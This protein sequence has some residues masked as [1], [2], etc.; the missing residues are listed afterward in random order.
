VTDTDIQ[1]FQE[2]FNNTIYPSPATRPRQPSTAVRCAHWLTGGLLTLLTLLIARRQQD[3]PAA[4]ITF[5]ALT[6][7]MLLL[8]PVC[9]LH[10]F[11]LSLPLAMGSL[12]AVWEGKQGL[13][14]RVATPSVLVIHGVAH[15]LPHFP[16]LQLLRDCGLA[17]Y[18]TLLLWLFGMVILLKRGRSQ[19][20]LPLERSEVSGAA[21]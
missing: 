5:G 1:S 20:A 8:S 11:C 10:Y 19:R 14:G 21:A 7:I 3:G 2:V 9:H 6:V 16:A 4:V 12:A 18:A 15:A 17:T 13:L